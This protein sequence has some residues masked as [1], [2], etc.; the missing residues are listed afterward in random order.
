MPY[1]WN[2]QRQIFFLLA[3]HRRA[4]YRWKG[5][6]E[7]VDMSH[8]VVLGYDSSF[9][10]KAK[11]SYLNPRESCTVNNNPVKIS[12]TFL[13]IPAQNCLHSQAR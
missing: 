9:G 11:L 8:P 3:V 5:L 10:G 13:D 2:A 1:I 12:G 6:V 7:A 4:T